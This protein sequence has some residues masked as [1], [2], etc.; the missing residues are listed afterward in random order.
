M[1]FKFFLLLIAVSTLSLAKELS[2]VDE[3]SQLF[4]IEGTASLR[5]DTRAPK[6]WQANSKVLIDHGK[7]IGFIT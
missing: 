2:K 7:Y 6:N 5:Q 4:T 3:A 1:I